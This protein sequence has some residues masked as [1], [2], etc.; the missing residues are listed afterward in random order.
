[1]RLHSALLALI[2]VA[3]STSAA[4]A[5]SIELANPFHRA[6][7]GIIVVRTGESIGTSLVTEEVVTAGPEAVL[8]HDLGFAVTSASVK[9]FLLDVAATADAR[10][11]AALGYQRVIAEGSGW[12]E[13]DF[14]LR[15]GSGP[16]DV[17][18]EAAQNDAY[19]TD[20]PASYYPGTRYVRIFEGS[21]VV[22]GMTS[23]QQTLQV[24][25]EYDVPYRLQVIFN[26]YANASA[27]HRTSSL[28]DL[29][30]T[31]GFVVQPV[32][33]DVRPGDE[34]NRIP[35]FSHAV[36]P[37]A[38]LGSDGFDVSDVDAATLAFGPLGAPAA[39]PPGGKRRDVNGDG[40]P[41]LVAHYRVA[42]TGIAL[43]DS[44]ACLT[45]ETLDG[46]LFEGCDAIST[47]PPACGLGLELALLLPMLRSLR[48]RRAALTT[49][50]R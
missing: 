10:D 38:L 21:T 49:M 19:S 3:P 47:V 12:Y 37:V 32:E 41:D 17:L 44:E 6:W 9:P 25:L 29:E 16:V 46:A 31:L 13:V 35:P 30:L 14:T 40:I 48:R 7:N 45:G 39:D 43:G 8:T 28:R 23:R 20:D 15:G 36:V 42:E 1:M 50:R 24:Q 4:A 22:A 27:G 5:R 18:L 26:A 11:V 2:L 33:I 34:R